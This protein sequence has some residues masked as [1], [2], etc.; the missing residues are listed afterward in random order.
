[1]S[2][3]QGI[4]IR[5]NE[6]DNV[7]QPKLAKMLRALI[8]AELVTLDEAIA[9]IKALTPAANKAIYFTSGTTAALFD[10][11]P[12]A[13]SILNDADAASVRTT[14][15]FNEAVDDRVG[16][17]LIVAGANIGTVYDDTAGTLTIS[18]TGLGTMASQNANNVAITG[19]TIAGL[20]SLAVAGTGTFSG[21]ITAANL[22]TAASKNTGTSG[23][24]V[25]LLNAFNIFSA[26]FS[27]IGLNS[28]SS[29]NIK[30][31][32]YDNGVARGSFGANATFCFF[33]GDG[34]GTQRFAVNAAT[35]AVACS[36]P[37]TTAAAANLHHSGVA[38]SDLLRSTSS[39]RYKTAIRPLRDDE[40]AKVLDL[41]PI[42]YR[43]TA[44]ADDGRKLHW[45]FTAEQVAEVAPWLVHFD[46]EGRPD[47]VQYERVVVGLVGVVKDLSARVAAL[48]A[49]AGRGR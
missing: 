44:K 15:E 12:F 26:P 32:L 29:N 21:N 34:G 39:A 24:A 4:T 10:L 6:P 46:A 27:V 49:G 14:L 16:G 31:L 18:V 13:R 42:A 2:L 48:E 20:T 28:T 8:A 43:S 45:G 37:G 36:T 19:G 11:T 3:L 35:G 25:P 1:M 41:E 22:G 30:L 40:S 38:N 47:A 33:A 9:A 5:P 23:D 7:R 17:S